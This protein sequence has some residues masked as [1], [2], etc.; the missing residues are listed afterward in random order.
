MPDP[1]L[2]MATQ[3]PI[4]SEGTYPLPEAQVDRFM[5]KVV[6]ELPDRAGGAR[7]RRSRARTARGAAGDAHP[8]GP[9]PHAGAARSRCTSTRPS[10]TTRSAWSRRPARPATVGLG[11]LDR[12]VT[13]RRQ[14]ARVHRPG[15]R[16]PGAGVP[17][18]PRLRAAARRRRARPWTCCGTASCC[19]TRRWPTTSTPTRSSPACWGPC[20][21]PTSPCRTA[22]P[23]RT[24]PERLLLRL[25]W[26]VIRRLDG[27]VQ[28]AYRTAYRGSGID[29]A[30]L[31]GY[32]EERRRPAHR[33]ERDRPAGRAA[34]AA[35]HRGPRADRLAG[36][37]PVG[38]DDG[39][40]AGPRQARRAGRARP[41]PGPAV[42]PRRQPGR[43]GAVRR[44]PRRGSCRRAPVAATRCASAHEL[45]RTAAA[46]PAAAP[47]TSPRCSTPSRRWPG[48]GR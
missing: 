46:A 12:Y 28:G 3:N 37:R 32:V 42:R 44:R 22:E 48:A 13:L 6:V 38:V 1:F 34:G 10:S 16:R 26:R 45:D 7:H 20:R 8:R 18:R 25:E 4:E 36:A 5:M 31:R 43:R 11:D 41:D 47:P 39:R 29:F 35:V 17:A 40:P 30:G 33:L 27:R 14:P 15:A 19:R 23:W 2:V 21:C 9:R 24:A